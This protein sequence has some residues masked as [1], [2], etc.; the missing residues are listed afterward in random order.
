MFLHQYPTVEIIAFK[1]PSFLNP[2]TY[3]DIVNALYAS[4]ISEDD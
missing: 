4:S 1:E 2:V 3:N